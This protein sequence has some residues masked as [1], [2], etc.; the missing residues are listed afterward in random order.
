MNLKYNAVLISCILLIATGVYA[1]PIGKVVQLVGNV[2]ITSMKTGKRTVPDLNTVIYN[3]DKIRTGKQSFV[4][5]LLNDGTKLFVKEI[6]VVNVAGLKLKDTDPPTKVRML[7]GK[8]RLIVKKTFKRGS[9]VLK[10]PTA[11]A[12]VRGTDFGVI[13]T[14]NETRVAVFEGEVEVANV[15]E[16]ILKSYVLKDREEVVVEKNSAPTS[17]RVVPSNVLSSWFDYYVIDD[18]RNK[19]I[20]RDR[21]D[22]LFD[23]LLRKKDY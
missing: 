7:T 21:E 12:G 11:I 6:S 1:K 5:I 16:N 17:P 19:I 4:T 2:D 14:R 15:K 3:D 23:R 8:L 9:L 18:R 20:R 10:T 13:T 22:S